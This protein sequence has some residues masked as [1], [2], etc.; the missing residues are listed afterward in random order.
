MTL[1]LH[2][3]DQHIP[4]LLFDQSPIIVLLLSLSVTNQLTLTDSD[5]DS[6]SDWLS[7]LTDV[8]LAFEDADSKLLDVISV[9]DVDAD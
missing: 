1:C 3:K 7:D 6:D 2:T 8:T 5:S 9:A 4:A